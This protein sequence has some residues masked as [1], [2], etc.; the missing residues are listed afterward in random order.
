MHG[1]YVLVPSGHAVFGA[2]RLWQHRCT[3]HL[4]DVYTRFAPHPTSR[5][6]GWGL[7][8][9]QALYADL[10]SRQLKLK[11]ADRTCITTTDA[12]RVCVTPKGLQ[13]DIDELVAQYPNG[14]CGGAQRRLVPG[15]GTGVLYDRHAWA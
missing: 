14:R 4:T 3:C 1:D 13:A 2:T 6:K 12:E 15:T 8:Q 9:W 11:V 7:P 5:R 10:P